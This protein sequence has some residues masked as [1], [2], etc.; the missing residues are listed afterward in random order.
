MVISEVGVVSLVLFSFV[1]SLG[2]QSVA[3]EHR[4]QTGGGGGV[5]LIDGSDVDEHRY[6]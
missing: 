5:C 2:G 1:S 3:T 4:H 6:V